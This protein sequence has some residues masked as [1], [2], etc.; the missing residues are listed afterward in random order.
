MLKCQWLDI[1]SENYLF[2]KAYFP[3]LYLTIDI[4]A[5]VRYNRYSSAI[6][7]LMNNSNENIKVSFSN[8]VKSLNDEKMIREI[9]LGG[10]S[11]VIIKGSKDTTIYFHNMEGKP[12]NLGQS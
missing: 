3:F 10:E 8:Q 1:I 7:T 12:F 5:F 6:F 4:L 2:Q 9:I 11:A